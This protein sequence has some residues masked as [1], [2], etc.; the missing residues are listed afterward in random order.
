[1]IVQCA[2]CQKILGE[3]EGE[4]MT[5][6]ICP[7]CLTLMEEEDEVRLMQR[8]NEHLAKSSGITGMYPLL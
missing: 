1:M 4:G 3:K 8:R 5:H 6:T 2:W 7:N